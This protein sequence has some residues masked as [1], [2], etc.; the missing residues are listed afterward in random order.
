MIFNTESLM[1]CT[2]LSVELFRLL[3]THS[4]L[5]EG[6]DNKARRLH[7]SILNWDFIITTV[8]LQHVF[9]CT[10]RLSVYLQVSITL[11]LPLL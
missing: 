5:S 11:L 2:Y 8:I 10:H 6:G 9:E 1:M 7:S 4:G 3:S